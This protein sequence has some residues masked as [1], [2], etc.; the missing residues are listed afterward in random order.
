MRNIRISFMPVVVVAMLHATAALLHADRVAGDLSKARTRFEATIAELKQQ[1]LAEL[2]AGEAAARQAGNRDKLLQTER[3]RERFNA[4]GRLPPATSEK[5]REKWFKAYAALEKSHEA[6]IAAY[7][8]PKSRDDAAA[9]EVQASLDKL[10]DEIRD[11]GV[12]LGVWRPLFDGK[13]TNGWVAQNENVH[14]EV[15][16]RV[17]VG[18]CGRSRGG[19]LFSSRGDF[20]NVSLRVVAMNGQGLNS[21]IGVRREMD[22]GNTGYKVMIDGDRTDEFGGTT[23]DLKAGMKTAHDQPAMKIPPNVWYT[24]ELTAIDNNITLKLNGK[25]VVEY[26]DK[27]H[28]FGAGHV[29]LLCRQHSVVRFAKV[30]VMELPSDD[31]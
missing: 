20:R 18:R 28:Q 9:D 22:D 19:H 11:R 1:T 10:R 21:A 23:G 3:A 29:A 15:E 6:A 5:L 12:N 25:R 27:D 2:A 14:W 8:K 30:E 16:D 4:N 26:N 24:L 13:T 7:T 17:L 31:E